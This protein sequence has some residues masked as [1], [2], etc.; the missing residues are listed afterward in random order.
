MCRPC[1]FL[2]LDLAFSPIVLDKFFPLRHASLSLELEGNADCQLHGSL[3][4]PSV[5]LA[6]NALSVMWP[7]NI[8]RLS[9]LKVCVM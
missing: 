2:L 3:R 7:N 6:I 8:G 9:G 1:G 4:K 5:Q